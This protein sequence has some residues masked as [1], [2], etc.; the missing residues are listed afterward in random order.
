MLAPGGLL[1][2]LKEEW[3]WEKGEV[4]GRQKGRKSAVR[5]LYE[6]RRKNEFEPC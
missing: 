6:E 2:G 3:I 1:S 4:L 5:M